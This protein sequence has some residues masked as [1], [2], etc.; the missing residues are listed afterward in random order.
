[1]GK[2]VEILIVE[3]YSGKVKINE[4]D[5]KKSLINLTD[6]V[7]ITKIHVP[8]WISNE[9]ESGILGVHVIVREIAE[10]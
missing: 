7:I 5:V 8:Q 9:E 4:Q 3:D 2:R 10:T 1:M 6:D